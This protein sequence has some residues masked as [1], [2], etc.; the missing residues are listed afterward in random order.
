M[1]RGPAIGERSVPTKVC[2]V[3][4][5]AF[6]TEVGLSEHIRLGNHGRFSRRWVTGAI[7]PAH[8]ASLQECGRRVAQ[9]NNSRRRCCEGCGLTTTAAALGAHQK[10]SGHTGWA[11]A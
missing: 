1:T 10:A 2:T 5:D 6:F 7:S 9:L 3:C 11:E 8:L 4:G